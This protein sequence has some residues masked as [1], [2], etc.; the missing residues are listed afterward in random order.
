ME[1]LCALRQAG[2]AACDSPVAGE[3]DESAILPNAMPQGKPVLERNA[4]P[5]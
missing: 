5:T 1:G 2:L 4:D 3:N